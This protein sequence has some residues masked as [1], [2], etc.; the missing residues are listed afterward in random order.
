MAIQVLLPKRDTVFGFQRFLDFGIARRSSF[1]LF[2]FCFVFLFFGGFVCL[3]CSSLLHFC[4]QKPFSKSRSTCL[5]KK[6][7]IWKLFWSV[8]F[9][10][11]KQDKRKG[12]QEL[13]LLSR[14]LKQKAFQGR[15][16]ID[17]GRTGD[18]GPRG[19]VHF[20]PVEQI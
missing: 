8:C 5:P 7:Q 12:E 18:Q 10:K 11:A 13:F 16:K 1:F 4:Q 2:C 3:F 6:E 9:Q 15:V 19:A 17:V 14:S 20:L